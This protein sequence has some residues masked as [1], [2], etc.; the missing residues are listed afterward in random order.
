MVLDYPAVLALRSNL[1]HTWEFQCPIRA[2]T[3]CCYFPQKGS[4]AGKDAAG[5]FTNRS[6]DSQ[7]SHHAFLSR[8]TYCTVCTLWAASKCGSMRALAVRGSALS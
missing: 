6:S 1:R 2:Q 3:Q 7:S 4:E 5:G 8:W